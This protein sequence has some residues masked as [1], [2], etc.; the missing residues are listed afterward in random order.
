MFQ[1][2]SDTVFF[3][4]TSTSVVFLDEDKKITDI[5]VAGECLSGYRQEELK[6]LLLDEL[7]K[8]IQQSNLMWELVEKQHFWEGE[9]WNIHKTGREYLVH[10]TVVKMYNEQKETV[11]IVLSKDITEMKRREQHYQDLLYKDVVTNL[12]T[13]QLFDET[14]R[15]MMRTSRRRAERLAVAV[16]D[17]ARFQDVNDSFGYENGD[18]VLRELVQR[19]QTLL[20]DDSIMTRQNSDI[21]MIACPDTTYNET[22]EW[23]EKVKQSFREVPFVIAGV[24][25]FLSLH[26]GVGMFPDDGKTTQEL[27]RKAD[28]TRSRVKELSSEMYQFYKPDKNV[29]VFEKLILE[30]NLRRALQQQELELY[31][32]PQIHMQTGNI[33][34]VEALIRWNHPKLGLISPMTFIPLAEE[35]GLIVPIGDWTIREGCRQIKEWRE[36]YEMQLTMG[37]NLSPKQFDNDHLV[38]DIAAILQ[39]YSIPSKYLELE[40]TEHVMMEREENYIGRLQQLRDLGIVLSIDDFGTGYSSL[41]YLA[42]FPIDFLKIDRSFVQKLMDSKIDATIVH[43]IIAMAHEL[44]LEVVAEGVETEEHLR[45]LEEMKC[46]YA[47][48]YFVGKPM[49]KHD[50]E[51]FIEQNPFQKKN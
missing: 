27:I 34:G 15:N 45:M 51:R 33:T 6:G 23:L 1:L 39:E 46:D 25:T 49:K 36:K 37:I 17:I 24:E 30:N 47:Q 4:R 41:S 44:G 32:Q 26:I 18:E 40:I 3:K 28:S 35:T 43:T 19:V 38:Q 2:W 29:K 48:G 10:R 7:A 16:F 50:I 20:P 8:D 5:N 22:V 12:P 14:I 21:F 11:Y 13:K 9:F 31:Y 42:K